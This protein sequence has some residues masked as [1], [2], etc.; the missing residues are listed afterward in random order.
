MAQM[1]VLLIVLVGLVVIPEIIIHGEAFLHESVVGGAGASTVLLRSVPVVRLLHSCPKTRSPNRPDLVDVFR[2][3][4]A[5]YEVDDA[6]SHLC[7]RIFKINARLCQV[8]LAILLGSGRS[9]RL[10]NS[11]HSADVSL[12]QR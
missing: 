8:S 11:V 10:N 5:D 12:L 6:L 3:H 9:Q 7:L 4:V 2:A 1:R